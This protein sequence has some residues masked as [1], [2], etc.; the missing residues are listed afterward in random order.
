MS[1]VVLNNR[2]DLRNGIKK[3]MHRY[4]SFK[5]D[6]FQGKIRQDLNLKVKVYC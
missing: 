5:R 1:L 2:S 6:R 3:S 4:N